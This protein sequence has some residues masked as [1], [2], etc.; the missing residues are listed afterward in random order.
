MFTPLIWDHRGPMS[1]PLILTWFQSQLVCLPFSSFWGMTWTIFFWLV[2][3]WRGRLSQMC[4]GLIRQSVWLIRDIAV[5]NFWFVSSGHRWLVG[6][7][8][9]QLGLHRKLHAVL[10]KLT[11]SPELLS[12]TS[13]SYC[14]ENPF[15]HC[16]AWCDLCWNRL[17]LIGVNQP[18]SRVHCAETHIPADMRMN[19]A[20]CFKALR[21]ISRMFRQPA[22]PAFYFDTAL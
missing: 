19:K 15:G 5:T 13:Q 2:E 1:Y 4:V 7:A 18:H 17:R 8:F 22:L 12:S 20:F 10:A 14:R 16:W 3:I 9:C 21:N 11:V 6:Q